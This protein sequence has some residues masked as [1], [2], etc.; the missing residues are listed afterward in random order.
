[1]IEA[2]IVFG[3][4]ARFWKCLIRE[5]KMLKIKYTLMSINLTKWLG[6]FQTFMEEISASAFK[7]DIRVRRL[8][9]TPLCV[10]LHRTE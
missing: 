6:Y 10:I 3:F 8:S 1:M 2:N 5:T 4:D 7:F 9:V